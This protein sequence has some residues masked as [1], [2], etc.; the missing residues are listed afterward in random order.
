LFS[1]PVKLIFN[2]QYLTLMKNST[3]LLAAGLA[4]LLAG[5]EKEEKPYVPVVRCSNFTRNIDTINMYINGTWEFL[6]ELRCGRN[7]CEYL[8]PESPRMYKISLKLSGDTARFYVNNQ[9]DS[10][11]QYRIQWL[12]EFTNYP[13]DT[14]P[15]LVY[16][17]FYTGLR[18]SQVP[19]MI[20]SNQILMQHQFVSSYV[21]E[22]LWMRK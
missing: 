17:S 21:G 2:I 20:C 16:Y 7:G 14:L 8:T 15:V 3:L 12:Y 10:I 6:E 22:R 5:C 11:Y 19:I 4:L 13:G 18:K 1:L 9:P